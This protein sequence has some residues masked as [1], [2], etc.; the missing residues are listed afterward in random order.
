LIAANKPTVVAKLLLD[1]VVVE[2]GQCNGGFANST[3]ADES[4]WSELLGEID[5]L[6]DQL[7]AS[8]ERL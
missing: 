7:V 3:S 1:L 8:K 6:L 4:D 5:N 2:D